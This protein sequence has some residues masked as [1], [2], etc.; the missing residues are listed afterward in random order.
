MHHLH[1]GCTSK[2]YFLTHLDRNACFVRTQG[3]QILWWLNRPFEGGYRPAFTAQQTSLIHSALHLNPT[4][5]FLSGDPL[6]S[7]ITRATTSSWNIGREI[8]WEK[9]PATGYHYEN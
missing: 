9:N 3:D 4:V 5:Y 7:H 6:W 8:V 2:L 1:S